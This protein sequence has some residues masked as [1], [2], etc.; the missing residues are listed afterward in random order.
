M[1]GFPRAGPVRLPE[2]VCETLPRGWYLADFLRK[3]FPGEALVIG[4][5]HRQILCLSLLHLWPPGTVLFYDFIAAV[6]ADGD[7]SEA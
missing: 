1:S 4:R 7:P 3:P 6:Q 5:P 2:S